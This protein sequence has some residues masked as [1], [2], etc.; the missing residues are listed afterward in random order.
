MARSRYADLRQADRTTVSKVEDTVDLDIHNEAALDAFMKEGLAEL[1]RTAM[2]DEEL[3]AIARELV[4]KIEPGMSP[5][6]E[7]FLRRLDE[8]AREIAALR[9]QSR[10]CVHEVSLRDVER[11]LGLTDL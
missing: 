1:R 8:I 5:I 2:T 9:R 3:D 4:S 11:R 10:P 7:Q 6:D